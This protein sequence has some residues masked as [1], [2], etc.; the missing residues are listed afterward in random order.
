VPSTDKI[1]ELGYCLWETDSRTPLLMENHIVKQDAPIPEETIRV[2]GITNEV[3]NKYG[4]PI[5]VAL[6]T[7][8]DMVEYHKPAYLVAHNGVNFDLPFLLAEYARH[9]IDPGAVATTPLIDTR[10]DIPFEVEPDS[11]K[12]KH[13]ALDHGFINPFPHRALFDVM[14]MLK[15]LSH[16]DI[17][18]I[19]EYQKI[20]WII[21]RAM[22]SYD[23]RDLAKAQRYSWQVVGDKTFPK[24]WVKAIKEN[25]LEKERATCPFQVVKIE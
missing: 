1:V 23:E 10:A 19:I 5:Q 11:R 14:A 21:V 12:L 22:V 18:K 4:E 17:A 2:H 24:A 3:A 13:L 9:G 8:R 16:H 20:P 7:F 6:N 25:H 15:V